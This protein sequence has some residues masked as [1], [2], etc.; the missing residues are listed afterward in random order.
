MGRTQP[1]NWWTFVARGIFA[2][3]FGVLALALPE[4]TLILLVWMF[5]AYIMIDGAFQ[6]MVSIARRKELQRWWM[7]LI[8][9]LF[10]IALGVVTFVWP[11]ITGLA[12]LTMI[13]IW[14]VVTGMLEIAAAI[15]LRKIIENEWMLGLSGVL[16]ILF[17]IAMFLWPDAGAL[18]LAWLIGLYAVLFGIMLV[19]LGFRLKDW[20]PMGMHA[21]V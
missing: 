8:E 15:Q 1:I 5:G 12:L 20:E 11:G 10:E 2:I 17:G 9:G 19:V 7:I 13:V 21:A 14:A 4:L 3:L 6:I 16:S 18:A